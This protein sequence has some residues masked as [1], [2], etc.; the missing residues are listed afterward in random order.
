MLNDVRGLL[1]DTRTHSRKMLA[2]CAN[3]N[4]LN[5]FGEGE[6]SCLTEE[7]TFVA[8]SLTFQRCLVYTR[9]QS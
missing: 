8:T 4:R 1:V 6:N 7:T 9:S 2:C 5:T 3:Y